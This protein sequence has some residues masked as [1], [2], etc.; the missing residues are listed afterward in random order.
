[1]AFFTFRSR[2]PSLYNLTFRIQR[3]QRKVAGGKKKCV[4]LVVHDEESR[5]LLIL[6]VSEARNAIGSRPYERYLPT[7]LIRPFNF[8]SI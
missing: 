5:R 3:H 7:Y 4:V 8:P 1:M 2:K 6:A